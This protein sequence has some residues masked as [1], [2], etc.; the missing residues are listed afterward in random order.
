M[1]LSPVN[2]DLKA[3]SVGPRRVMHVITSLDTGGAETMLANLVIAKSEASDP[4]VVVSMVTG[5]EQWDRIRKA[6]V[7]VFGLGM[8]RGR[9]A[10]GAAGQLAKLIK[11]IQPRF[12]QSWMYHAD[13]LTLVALYMSGRRNK[14]RLL[15][16]VRC[17]D[18]DVAR[19]PRSLR[20]VIRACALL[21][22]LPDAVVANSHAGR[23]VHRALGYGS[24]HFLVIPNGI[25][26][27]KFQPDPDA[28][29]KA[30]AELQVS[31]GDFV[32]G[33]AARVDPMK[34]YAG[35]LAAH[36][37]TA[38]GKLVVAGRDTE[39][40][41]DQE[42]L[43]RLGG[44]DDMPRLMNGFDA[45]VSASAFGEGFSNAVAEAMA[46][47]VGDSAMIVGDC[48]LVVPP[49][50]PKV[51]ATAIT[52]LKDDPDRRARLGRAARDRIETEFGIGRAVAAFD[53]LYT[54][55]VETS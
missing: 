55:A 25:D 8:T 6:G 52:S 26:T 41:P 3:K 37:Q 53:T 43:I 4:P 50:D 1:A 2:T 54:E 12:V 5:G 7:E 23:E 46:T 39:T 45:L 13:L 49:S 47:D 34:D 36:K 32:I 35:L 16:G 51:L 15:W 9:P 20:W 38:G 42:N 11:E 30:R 33:T 18:V 21:S 14:T 40:L 10:L 24:R 17:S 19:Y 31:D 27:K 29:T 44:R 22:S 48:G 28:R